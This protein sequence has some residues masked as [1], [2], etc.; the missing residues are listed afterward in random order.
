[1]LVCGPDGL[2]ATHSDIKVIYK[3]GYKPANL[4]IEIS[5][6]CYKIQDYTGEITLLPI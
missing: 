4:W 6:S 5:V 2:R 1:M 3:G